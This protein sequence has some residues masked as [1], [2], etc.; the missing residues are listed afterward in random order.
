MRPPQNFR[1]RILQIYLNFKVIFLGRK[2]LS[3]EDALKYIIKQWE[4]SIYSM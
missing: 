1:K 4:V 2:K 3:W